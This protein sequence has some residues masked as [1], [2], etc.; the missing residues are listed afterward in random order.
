MNS[1][2]GKFKALCYAFKDNIDNLKSKLMAPFLKPSFELK[3]ILSFTEMTEQLKK[4]VFYCLFRKISHQNWLNIGFYTEINQP[5]KE[6]VAVL[7][8]TYIP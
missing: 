4:E 7:L 3:L 2:R 1:T 6:K 8:S 5:L